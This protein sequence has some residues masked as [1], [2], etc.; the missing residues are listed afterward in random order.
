MALG[1]LIPLLFLALV[2]FGVRKLVSVSKERTGTSLSIRQVFQYL[3]LF[4]VV[5]IS[6]VGVSGLLG[7][8]L[9][10]NR[11]IA[12]DR[13]ALARN[14]T[15]TI[16]GLPL[17]Y[18]L[19]RWTSQSFHRAPEERLSLAWRG[20]LT[21][22]SITSLSLALSGFHDLLSWAIGNDPYSGNAISRAAIWTLVWVFYWRIS[23]TMTDSEAGIPHLVIGSAIGLS[24]ISVGIGGLIGNI[25][26][27]LLDS[28]TSSAIAETTNPIVNSSINILLGAPLWYQY[29]L[30]HL[31]NRQ[32]GLLWYLYI[33][34]AGIT[35]GFITA[36]ASTSVAIYDVLVW[37]FGDVGGKSATEHFISIAQ[38]IGSALIGFALWWY[39]RAVLGTKERS[40]VRRIYEYI[41]SGVSLIAAALGLLMIFVA[42]I[43]GLTPS[44]L[45]KSASQSNTLI[46]AITLLL[47]GTP[48]W[49]FFWNRIE[50]RI[51]EGGQSAENEEITSPTRRIFILMLF[52]VAGIAA[53]VSV[54]TSVFFLFDDLLNS[55]LALE[56]LRKARFALGILVTN[57]AIAGYHWSIYRH[58]K[59]FM[60]RRARAEKYVL[61]VGPGDGEIA[62]ELQKKIGGRVQLWETP[63]PGLH[64]SDGEAWDMEQIMSL[65]NDQRS[66]E[67]MILNEK[68]K[69]RAIP[70]HRP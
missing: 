55:Q 1:F 68:R 38:P 44:D 22:S 52:G 43:E 54:I 49:W 32:R 14:L 18:F 11:V 62:R 41:I 69:L 21:V 51:R 36:V 7:R 65:I 20:Y 27:S 61:L 17:T 63:E 46:V 58:E 50:K 28:G 10:F 9:D 67:I 6:G 42:V 16:V 31:K 47:V 39:H 3:I 33:F 66:N 19:A 60:V 24:I 34:L 29:W 70:I 23:K 8:V 26:E 64:V 48:V 57:G 35:A 53:V 45:V 56:T 25:I 13:T 4:G 15:F 2:I 12:E 59:E 5:I 37:F 40:E 30:R